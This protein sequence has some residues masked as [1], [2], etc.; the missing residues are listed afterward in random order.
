ML[1]IQYILSTFLLLFSGALVFWMAAGFSMLE[2][3]LVRASKAVEILKK[4]VG[5]YCVSAIFFAFGGYSI[6]YGD[7]TGIGHSSAADILFQM[8][9]VATA[10]S[11]ISGTIAERAKFWPFM[12]V[13][14]VLSILIYPIQGAWTWGGGFLSEMGFSDFAGSTI[15]HSVGGWAALAGAILLGSRRGRYTDD[16]SVN[17]W[18]FQPSNLTA[19][20]IGTF[21]LWLGWFGFNGGSQLAMATKADIDAIANVFANT[22]IAAVAGSL[23]AL[24][25]SSVI[26]KNINLPMMLNGALAGLVAIT[27]GPDY[28]SLELAV[29]IGAIGGAFMFIATPLFDRVRVDDPVGALSVHLVPGVWGTLAVGIFKPE[30]SVLVQL[31]GIGIIGAFV[32]ASSF[33]VWFILKKIMGINSEQ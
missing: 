18:E 25:L 8:V 23:M 15:V 1:D 17:T 9:F 28:P 22:H 13:V 30:V 33:I 14:A 19:A 5:L 4:N 24:A 2:C 11:I 31:Q 12:I 29:L 16:G 20:T 26:N 21:I 32:F 10:A 3:G 6:M 27:A 7:F